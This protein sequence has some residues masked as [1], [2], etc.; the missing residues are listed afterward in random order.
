MNSSNPLPKRLKAARNKLGISQQELGERIG[1][2]TSAAGSRINHYE[3]G[4]HEPNYQTLKLIAQ[5][6]VVST[7][8]L[9][10][11]DDRLAALIEAYDSNSTLT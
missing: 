8:Y 5:A 2:N 6:L 4:R 11:D 10:C 9:Y 3:K 7:S 1:L